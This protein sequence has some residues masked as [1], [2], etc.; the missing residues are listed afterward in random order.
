MEVNCRLRTHEMLTV[1]LRRGSQ[2]FGLYHTVTF[3]FAD[4]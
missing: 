2:T 3:K 1:H 4:T